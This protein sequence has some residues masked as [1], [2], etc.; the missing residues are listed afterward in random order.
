MWVSG[1]S[2]IFCHDI[3][4]TRNLICWSESLNCFRSLCLKPERAAWHR[5]QTAYT[6]GPPPLVFFP[7]QIASLKLDFNF[8]K[9]WPRGADAVKIQL[10]V[11]KWNNCFQDTYGVNVDGKEVLLLQSLFWPSIL[12]RNLQKPASLL[13]RQPRSGWAQPPALMCSF[14]CDSL[15]QIKV[16]AQNAPKQLKTIP[17]C[18]T[19]SRSFSFLKKILYLALT[20]WKC[21]ENWFCG[22]HETIPGLLC[23]RQ[24]S[25]WSHW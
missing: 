12:Q 10:L 24:A 16:L 3:L 17:L 15:L 7:F 23:R 21:F 6:S 13:L 22:L 1:C 4:I 5:P 11:S 19:Q 8:L 9:P 2:E 20:T 18:S 14:S 25:L